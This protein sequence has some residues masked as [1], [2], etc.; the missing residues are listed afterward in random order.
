MRLFFSLFPARSHPAEVIPVIRFAFM[1]L[2][3]DLG[4]HP[5]PQIAHD[6]LLVIGV[7]VPK[8]A[9][10]FQLVKCADDLLK[11]PV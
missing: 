10:S 4:V 6:E 1:N 2:G 9:L 3:Q 7:I 8:H 5:R 11:R